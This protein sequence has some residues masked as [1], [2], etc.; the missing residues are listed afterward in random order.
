MKDRQEARR[1]IEPMKNHD[2][3]LI[4][5]NFT[6]LGEYQA[7]VYCPKN[8]KSSFVPLKMSYSDEKAILPEN[9][10]DEYVSILTCALN[11]PESNFILTLCK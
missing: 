5:W 2:I 11:S 1:I 6:K 10:L 4:I 8:K 3:E 9:A 7:E